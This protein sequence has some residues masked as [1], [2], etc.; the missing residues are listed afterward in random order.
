MKEEYKLNK[1]AIIKAV[2]VELKHCEYCFEVFP[3]SELTD[4]HADMWRYTNT[5]T[6]LLYC[7]GCVEA[8]SDRQA[9]R[10]HYPN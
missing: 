6:E 10:H 7:D 9:E 4:V 2:D 3:K 5:P 8:E 1:K